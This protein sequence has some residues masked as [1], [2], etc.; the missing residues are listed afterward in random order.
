MTDNYNYNY[1]DD[2]YDESYVIRHDRY[3]VARVLNRQYVQ[4]WPFK[5]PEFIVPLPAFSFV[6]QCIMYNFA[7]NR[8]GFGQN[9]N[10]DADRIVTCLRL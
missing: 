6:F 3:T 8:D 4:I 1:N 10:R 7:E 2:D 9:F 5:K